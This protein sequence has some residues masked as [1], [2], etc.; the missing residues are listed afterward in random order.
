MANPNCVSLTKKEIEEAIRNWLTHPDKRNEAINNY[1]AQQVDGFDASWD[2]DT[3][4]KKLFPYFK[5]LISS[6][7]KGKDTVVIP[8]PT[9]LTLI[10][11]DDMNAAIEEQRTRESHGP[12]YI[13]GNVNTADEVI[14]G[15]LD[16]TLEIKSGSNDSNTLA[17]IVE[18]QLRAQLADV[19]I[20][21]DNNDNTKEFRLFVNTIRNSDYKCNV[22]DLFNIILA[23]CS[24]KEG[25]PKL[26][27]ANLKKALAGDSTALDVCY[28]MVDSFRRDRLQLSGLE[29]KVMDAVLGIYSSKNKGLWNALS[30]LNGREIRA[31]NG[32]SR[33]DKA[34]ACSLRSMRGRTGS[35]NID[36]M[37]VNTPFNPDHQLSVSIN[38]QI[39]DRVE[40]I[41][42]NMAEDRG[43]KEEGYEGNPYTGVADFLE[44]LL[45]ESTEVYSPMALVKAVSAL[46]VNRATYHEPNGNFTTENNKELRKLLLTGNGDLLIDEEYESGDSTN[47]VKVKRDADGQYSFG[48]YRDD[49]YNILR[50]AYRQAIF[51]GTSS[52]EVDAMMTALRKSEG[53]TLTGSNE[54]FYPE[55]MRILEDLRNEAAADRFEE[56]YFEQQR[57][58]VPDNYAELATSEKLY[59]ASTITGANI[60]YDSNTLRA[61]TNAICY[62]ILNTVDELRYR[63]VAAA[64]F[65]IK[66]LTSKND[67]LEAEKNELE[68]LT[69]KTEE[70][71]NKIAELDNT[72]KQNNREIRKARRYIADLQDDNAYVRAVLK[73]KAASV[74]KSTFGK[75]ENIDPFVDK[76]GNPTE[77]A[78]AFDR[79]KQEIAMIER[80]RPELTC[81][82]LAQLE[83][84][85]GIHITMN[86]QLTYEVDENQSNVNENDEEGSKKDSS[87]SLDY[88]DDED[89][90]A[91][92]SQNVRKTLAMIPITD[93]QGKPIL[94]DIGQVQY[95]D[96]KEIMA[97]LLDMMDGW[98]TDTEDFYTVIQRM[99]KDQ[100][101]NS[102]P[103]LDNT[104]KVYPEILDAMG[105]KKGEKRTAYEA[106]P[107]G[108]PDFTILKKSMGKY[109]WV[110]QLVDKL[111]EGWMERSE[112]SE[113]NNPANIGMTTRDLYCELGH[114]FMKR[115]IL[116]NNSFF[117]TNTL[118]AVDSA[119]RSQQHNYDNRIKLEETMLYTGTGQLDMQNLQYLLTRIN[120]LPTSEEMRSGFMDIDSDN[121]REDTLNRPNSTAV[122]RYASALTD[123]LR[124]MGFEV[125]YEDIASALLDTEN[126]STQSRIY[127]IAKLAKGVL[128]ALN[129]RGEVIP[130]NNNLYYKAFG[131]WRR[132]WEAA[133]YFVNQSNYQVSTTENGQ[134]RY[135]YLHQNT[136]SK[137]FNML[138]YGYRGLIYGTEE[139]RKKVLED[140]RKKIDSFFRGIEGF[141]DEE[142]G[143]YINPIIR[144]L[145]EGRDI[146]TADIGKAG[147]HIRAVGELVQVS[148]KDDAELSQMTPADQLAVQ[149]G[150]ALSHG[151]SESGLVR[152]PTMADAPIMQFVSVRFVEDPVEEMSNYVEMDYNRI[153]ARRKEHAKFSM[154]Y[155]ISH[156]K[157]SNKRKTYYDYTSGSW[158][159][160]W[161]SDEWKIYEACRK[162]DELSDREKALAMPQVQNKYPGFDFYYEDY[163]KYKDFV[164]HSSYFTNEKHYGWI[165]EIEYDKFGFHEIVDAIIRN[166]KDAHD[167]NVTAEERKERRE[168]IR[169]TYNK[170]ADR[171]GDKRF[172]MEE[173]INAIERLNPGVT[174]SAGVTK[175]IIT[176][177]TD[178]TLHKK[179][180]EEMKSDDFREPMH[181][182]MELA[183][184]NRIEM[185]LQ[186][187]A[188]FD[189]DRWKVTE[190]TEEVDGKTKTVFNL[191]R[192]DDSYSY[193]LSAVEARYY[194]ERTS[195]YATYHDNMLN[196][197]I[198]ENVTIQSPQEWYRA[199]AK[200]GSPV[201]GEKKYSRKAIAEFQPPLVNQGD[202]LAIMKKKD[203]HAKFED[204][205]AEVE[206]IW[207]QTYVAAT[208]TL[209][210]VGMSPSMFPNDEE[211]TKRLKGIYSN[212]LRLDTNSPIGH[213]QE[214]YIIIAD[215][216]A[217]ISGSFLD[218][219][220]A[221]ADMVKA[222]DLKEDEAWEKCS[223]YMK[224]NGSDAQGLIS[225]I[226]YRAKASMAGSSYWTAQMEQLFYD[227]ISG[228][229]K[230]SEFKKT[231]VF[232]TIKQVGMAPSAET[233]P[234]GTK[235]LRCQFIKNSEACM[236]ANYDHLDTPPSALLTALDRFVSNTAFKD[237]ETDE[238]FKITTIQR[239]SGVKTGT[240]GVLDLRYVPSR[241][242]YESGG[243]QWLMIEMGK[244]KTAA[245]KKKVLTDFCDRWSDQ[246]DNVMN[247]GPGLAES[248]YKFL[249]GAMPKNKDVEYLSF[250]DIDGYIHKQLK[251]VTQS[252]LKRE[253]GI[254]KES[255]DKEIK[256][257]IALRNFMM[258]VKATEEAVGELQGIMRENTLKEDGT[259][260]DQYVYT[261]DPKFQAMQ[262]RQSNHYFD[263]QSHLGSQLSFLITTGVKDNEDY[264]VEI[265]G[266]PTT[267]KGYE[268][269][270]RF[271]ACLAARLLQGVNEATGTFKDIYKLR[272][273]MRQVIDTNPSYGPEIIKA[274]NI[275]DIAVG[276]AE[277]K[278]RFE[279]PLAS[280]AVIYKVSD[281]LTSIIRNNTI[282]KPVNGGAVVI[283]EDSMYDEDL[284]IE[285]E[286]GKP[287][288]V[289]CLISPSSR[290]MLRY[291]IVKRRING[292][293]VETLDFN[294][295]KGTG[296][297]KIIGYRIPTEEYH[298]MLP[299]IIKGPLPPESGAKIVVAKDIVTLTGGDN[300]VDKLFLMV[301]N[302]NKELFWDKGKL[303]AVKYD[304]DKPVLEQKNEAI[305][306]MLIDIV[307]ATLTAKQNQARWLT[308]Q[309]PDKLKAVAARIA[310]QKLPNNKKLKKRRTG[311]DAGKLVYDPDDPKWNDPNEFAIVTAEEAFASDENAQ[312]TARHMR[313]F[314]LHSV[315]S[316]GGMVHAH[317]QHNLAKVGVAVGADNMSGYAKVRSGL[318]AIG[319]TMRF[320]T[321]KTGGLKNGIRIDGVELDEYCP[322]TDVN[323]HSVM[324]NC[325][326]LSA[327]FVDSGKSSALTD[328]GI[329]LNNASFAGFLLK[330]GFSFDMM[331]YAIA[332]LNKYPNFSSRYDS[333]YRKLTKEGGVYEQAD[334]RD[335]G[336]ISL[337]TMMKMVANGNDLKLEKLSDENNLDILSVFHTLRFFQRVHDNMR[338]YERTLKFN[339]AKHA[340][341]NEPASAVWA[342]LLVDRVEKDRE[343]LLVYVPEQMI[344]RNGMSTEDIEKC[345]ITFEDGR[346][347]PM[348]LPLPQMYYT[349]GIESF[350]KVMKDR[351]FYAHPAFTAL[352]RSF[353]PLIEKLPKDKGIKFIKQLHDEFSVFYL[354]RMKMVNERY[355]AY[356]VRRS[357]DFTDVRDYYRYQ[358][359]KEM[360]K[361]LKDQDL[362]EK[363]AILRVMTVKDGKLI[364]DSDRKNELTKTEINASLTR[365]ANSA[366]KREKEMARNIWLCSFFT[367]GLR[368]SYGAL[369][370]TFEPS[371]LANKMFEEYN[372]SVEELCTTQTVTGDDL[373]N[374][375]TQ[376]IRNNYKQYQFG[377]LIKLKTFIAKND[378]GLY[379]AQ[380]PEGEIELADDEVTPNDVKAF[381]E[382]LTDRE[383]NNMLYFDDDPL[384]SKNGRVRREVPKAI[385]EKVKDLEVGEFFRLQVSFSIY[386]QSLYQVR[387][388]E[389][390]NKYVTKLQDFLGDKWYCRD[391][392]IMAQSER[393]C[394]VDERGKTAW[395]SKTLK[396]SVKKKYDEQK[397]CLNNGLSDR[398][399]RQNRKVQEGDT[400][401]DERYAEGFD[402]EFS[403]SDDMF[404]HEDYE[405]MDLSEIDMNE[406]NVPV[407]SE[408]KNKKKWN[409]GDKTV[410]MN[411]SFFDNLKEYGK[412][413][414]DP[415]ASFTDSDEDFSVSLMA[416][417]DVEERSPEEDA[418]A[419][420]QLLED[421]GALGAFR[422][423]E[424]A[425]RAA[426]KANDLSRG[427]VALVE[428]RDGEYRVDLHDISNAAAMARWREQYG[429]D[430][431]MGENGINSIMSQFGNTSINFVEDDG[432]TMFAEYKDML[433]ELAKLIRFAKSNR[434]IQTWPKIQEKTALSIVNKLRGTTQFRRMFDELSSAL[435]STGGKAFIQ[436]LFSGQEAADIVRELDDHFSTGEVL[437]SDTMDRLLA[438]MLA[439]PYQ[440]VTALGQNSNFDYINGKFKD[441]ALATVRRSLSA[442]SDDT[443][444][445]LEEL[446]SKAEYNRPATTSE[447]RRAARRGAA[448]ARVI[449]N[450]IDELEK[451]LQKARINEERRY[452]MLIE[453]KY[454]VHTAQDRLTLLDR[455][456]EGILGRGDGIP[457][458]TGVMNYLKHMKDEYAFLSSQLEDIA[459]GVAPGTYSDD[460]DKLA[461]MRISL[462]AHEEILEALTDLMENDEFRRRIDADN[463]NS[464]TWAAIKK[465]TETTGRLHTNMCSRFAD[466]AATAFIGFVKDF[467]DINDT[468]KLPGRGEVT[469]KQLFESYDGD[470]SWV[471]MYLR[472]MGD[473]NDP[474]G[475]LYDLVVK[476]EKDRIRDVAIADQQGAIRS[477]NDFIIA[478]R[479]SDFEFMFE[480]DAEGKKTGFYVT[481]VNNG[482]FEKAL[483]EQE[484]IRDSVK[485]DPASTDQQRK[486]ADKAYDD[487]VEKYAN[488]D[489][490]GH[491]S[492]KEEVR[493]GSTRTYPWINKEWDAIQADPVKKEFMERFMA[494]KKTFDGR[495]G[496]HTAHERAIQRRMT[497]EQRFS[498]NF[499]LSPKQLWNNTKRRLAEDFLA[500]E[501]DY[502]EA[503]ER[504]TV[505]DFD[506]TERMVMPAPFVRML[507]NP[508]EL[509]TDPI[510]CLVA[511]SYASANYQ[512]MRKLVNPLEV[513][514]DALVSGRIQYDE[515]NGRA[516]VERFRNG[517]KQK[518]KV[519]ESRF[520]RKLRSFLDTQLYMR[521]IADKDDTFSIMGV[522]F[523][524]SKV[525]NA[526]LRM[527]AIA[528]LGFN[529]LVDMANLANGLA[530]TN[531]EAAARRYFS[532]TTL[533]KADAE[534]FKALK[535]FIPDLNN[536]IKQSKLA[537][538][539]EKLDI[540]QNFDVKIYNNR[541]NALISKLFNSQIAFMGTTCGNHWLY[542][543]VAIARMLS[544]K[545]F[546]PGEGGEMVETNLWD[547]FELKDTESGG[548][549][550]VVPSG[551]KLE[552]GTVIDDNWLHTFGRET[553]NI[554]HGLIGIYNRDD[555][556]MAQKISW[557][558][559]FIAFRK[560]IVPLMDKRWRKK[561]INE[562]GKEEEGYMRTFG[563]MLIAL[564]NAQ[565]NVPAV[566][567]E[568]SEDD[569]AAVR[570]A[571]T[572]ILQFAALCILSA[573]AFGGDDD[574]DDD[575][576]GRLKK[577]CKFLVARERHELGSMLP[578][579][580]A[581]KEAV[582]MLNQPVMGTS[583]LEDV[584]NFC[585]TAFTPWTWD[586]RVKAGPFQ[587]QTQIEMRFR[588]LPIPVLSYYRNIDKSMNGINNS[589][590]FY[591]RGYVGNA[592]GGKV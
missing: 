205:P 125:R 95:H 282:R 43:Y 506:G 91:H 273:Y 310:Y 246:V 387:E 70:Q 86:S 184:L 512:G 187:R 347:M 299:L 468:I 425:M 136:L 221:Y 498:A 171:L 459:T 355:D 365:M 20:D 168:A 179:F 228:R 11:N 292:K 19:G 305:E 116:K 259:F 31:A 318:N 104:E 401:V 416:A 107:F 413:N 158:M 325:S 549:I 423:R 340:L 278:P 169:E 138:S 285:Y 420:R 573:L 302:I 564:K 317:R 378:E 580:Y 39:L 244:A 346:V 134:T 515:Q 530:Q 508:D 377:T 162:F 407:F 442:L 257:L 579:L 550:A 284:K 304:W 215:D 149:L 487:W 421:A 216:T 315:Q 548:K 582:N 370:N 319:E 527:S 337:K 486:A 569:R 375:A 288:G 139:S 540:M 471:D 32:S 499:T 312:I 209:Q 306:N 239:P 448:E 361:V 492:P 381:E 566:W 53:A 164:P 497:S 5:A 74:I 327:A 203:S 517:K 488:E 518:A 45:G 584:Y 77:T 87:D 394:M 373:A 181:M 574:D 17:D 551:A 127:S 404:L 231:A 111:T 359:P 186:G 268:I 519:K 422:T 253:G 577:I 402:A 50:I 183:T 180:T 385:L 500:Q 1:V 229:R 588:K 585:N 93:W 89:P 61:R 36:V 110:K 177:F 537:L 27:R 256:G 324:E 458:I 192:D 521:Y 68:K 360:E 52:V 452:K 555:M 49:V 531:I 240:K 150:A 483:R 429:K 30:K 457:N 409:R 520:L 214:R 34:L 272:D 463:P 543:R 434:R 242:G 202:L 366:S 163:K 575:E 424:D 275:I 335:F 559:L 252:R 66:K 9:Q 83:Q 220:D 511:Y 320:K 562:F 279:T 59:K 561:H 175:G 446:S 510:G 418:L 326:D 432:L 552:D 12:V 119:K 477:L 544:T 301:K 40:D 352:V 572:D 545:V 307:S 501:D 67:E 178:M 267:V 170:Y 25:M 198:T 234:D 265:N 505:L 316:M 103:N 152:L 18:Q 81:R 58:T 69:N 491:L 210:M 133:G 343:K 99:K 60:A 245:E 303:E 10:V 309:D 276:D 455:A 590:W 294:K 474:V 568:L 223:A 349:C 80:L 37:D 165:R 291:C 368:F 22:E 460:M 295:L 249:K 558:K 591:N 534:Y 464:A 73:R 556:V 47:T 287:V 102:V 449:F 237:P 522:E 161:E 88:R 300:D 44:Q 371:F 321:E 523:R 504:S 248:F 456:L 444:D 159:P 296:L 322:E 145:Y 467:I 313:R 415:D 398:Q 286:N 328:I 251:A 121:L 13:G 451:I 586:E 290:E 333:I 140:R 524:K 297:D 578:T 79:R 338:N 42:K 94:D 408:R 29:K 4:I 481:R 143:Q 208:A 55:A 7:N 466:V 427:Y 56:E 462:R 113:N 581:P 542:H 90:F 130:E 514:F 563:S 182:H 144:D 194:Q 132:L 155:A 507:K 529:W 14:T 484:K 437:S 397:R 354:S 206:R 128:D 264:T 428:E 35:D 495:L 129:T 438:R 485:N 227:V 23:A 147:G 583:Q 433:E 374:F 226:G 447:H 167:V 443:A 533:R 258:P 82:A 426:I 2:I 212:G 46:A 3:K 71:E 391:M 64:D 219:V 576:E 516:T 117:E 172:T 490:S 363:Y 96:P 314:A 345:Q 15:V 48:L 399:E 308:P 496:E 137:M 269:Y 190:T 146:A 436:A 554:N 440:T 539:S 157:V 289:Q 560:H 405:N 238:E 154:I 339:S 475:Q 538:V 92:L 453:G 176:A 476:K 200:K 509:S 106:F 372:Q 263:G 124:S 389:D 85:T 281:I 592:H 570:M 395:K 24:I 6:Y 224:I 193:P 201:V 380:I 541:R 439:N 222:G 250:D 204:V 465:L 118:A 274:L 101:G 364:V 63:E 478:N 174:A 189:G 114:T 105:N 331:A 141:Y 207:Y 461:R 382:W 587:G 247:L 350:N 547:A 392:N 280:V 369:S 16:A 153:Q 41:L 489:A 513:G 553:D 135:N 160:M 126:S 472:S 528:Q 217:A 536:P 412:D 342:Q 348:G 410:I 589:T 298:S 393:D 383:T 353:T 417:L 112:V 191:V 8:D 482:A 123:V 384:T 400:V 120:S 435:D 450:E 57:N 525:I 185:S 341:S 390:G 218:I 411:E 151:R 199:S 532:G 271:Y 330:C 334:K 84:I 156:G 131:P 323:G 78:E 255:A 236:T 329:N 396:D 414:Y 108:K 332:I 403:S 406:P 293:L 211:L 357:D 473:T 266:V 493:E 376:F 235:T 166:S 173:F 260:N 115:A 565:F 148:N 232:N 97:A 479:L 311:P 535:D 270:D 233:N 503:G 188:D 243:L 72:I 480:H 386:D 122:G 213:K 445:R 567:N 358:F 38:R 502:L 54:N 76:D 26:K 197:S 454:D 142:K 98:V 470:I 344:I 100:D 546:V 388:D 254:S 336:N 367:D 362:R 283:E 33:T 441:L 351:L 277:A 62:G 109:P 356:G 230:L 261:V 196:R 65:K 526:F 379:E 494:I 571:I 431:I 75:I 241:I 419:R 469:W 225:L 28:N 430:V 262:V 557:A 21:F 51:G 195:G